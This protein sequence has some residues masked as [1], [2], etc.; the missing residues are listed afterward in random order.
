MEEGITFVT[1]QPKRA[2][3]IVSMQRLNRLSRGFYEM[4]EYENREALI[5][6]NQDARLLPEETIEYFI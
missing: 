4:G 5:L 6:F 2:N 1:D 3:R